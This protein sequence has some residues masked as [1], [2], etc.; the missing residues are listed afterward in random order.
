MRQ[1][2]TEFSWSKLRCAGVLNQ[3]QLKY[4]QNN[5]T[6]SRIEYGALEHMQHMTNQSQLNQGKNYIE[7]REL[8]DTNKMYRKLKE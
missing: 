8:T 7:W 4:R 2:W 1:P 3:V 5:S 6:L